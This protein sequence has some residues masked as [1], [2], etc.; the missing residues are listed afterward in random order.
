MHGPPQRAKGQRRRFAEWQIQLRRHSYRPQR[1]R[2]NFRNS[3]VKS[4]QFQ[5]PQSQV[6]KF[7]CLKFPNSKIQSSN[8]LLRRPT[9]RA[10]VIVGL[11]AAGIVLP[12]TRNG[13]E[14]HSCHRQNFSQEK[15]SKWRREL[16]LQPPTKKCTFMQQ[17][18]HRTRH[19]H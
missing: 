13:V 4:P 17:L 14:K 8:L 7:S 11:V 6:T 10:L 1:H 12:F 3:E 19:V 18:T 15:G 2:D 9:C 16:F 5:I